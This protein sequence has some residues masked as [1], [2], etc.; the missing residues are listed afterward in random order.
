VPVALADTA[1]SSTVLLPARLVPYLDDL[2]RTGLFGKSIEEV[3]LTL[4]EEA[5]RCKVQEGLIRA[6]KN[7]KR[8]KE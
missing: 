7:G 3:A 4:I 8:V 1:E 5:L 2:G 6:R